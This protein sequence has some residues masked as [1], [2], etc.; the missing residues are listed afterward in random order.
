MKG[1]VF[2]AFNDLVE[3]EFGIAVWEELLEAVN[4]DSHGI[5]TAV[6]DFP[7]DEMVAML[8]ELSKR[9]GIPA[10]E[11]LRVFGKFLFAVLARRH[12]V[13]V[14]QQ[15]DFFEFLSSIDGV[16]HKE[17]H[18]LYENPHLPV[19]DAK[20]LD[21]NT[22]QVSYRSPR[23]LCHLAVG[24]IEGAADHYASTVS[25]SHNRCMHDGADSC[26]LVISKV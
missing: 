20:A 16:I 7:D 14:D 5:Y 11:L 17:V 24:L 2:T 10:E 3:Q 19:M 18:K 9:T 21:E 1:V 4:P 26:E 23:K 12:A 6:E 25:V 15:P 13:F 8:G 22:L